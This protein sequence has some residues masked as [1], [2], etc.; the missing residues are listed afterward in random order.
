ML[1]RN[2][3]FKYPK[4]DSDRY[5]LKN[6]SFKL[7]RGQLCVI[8]GTNGSGALRSIFNEHIFTIST[9][10]ST[11]MKLLLRLY[12]PTEGSRIGPSSSWREELDVS[13]PLW[14]LTASVLLYIMDVFLVRL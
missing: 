5:V 14:L 4:S 12:D 8:V 2:V 10:K 6:A 11:L 7:E 3:S 1:C 9:G 13:T